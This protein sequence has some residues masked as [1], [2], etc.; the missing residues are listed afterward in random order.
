MGL[1]QTHETDTH[2]HDSYY[3]TVRSAT[4]RPT[5][6]DIVQHYTIKTDSN[7]S[8]TL[9]NVRILTCRRYIPNRKPTGNRA[10]R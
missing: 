9:L 7:N 10:G 2:W 5:W 1:C 8:I 3:V 6:H 4:G